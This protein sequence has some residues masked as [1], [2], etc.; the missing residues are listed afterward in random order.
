MEH[1]TDFTLA[2]L[3]RSNDQTIRRHAQ[4]IE[5]ALYR[6]EQQELDYTP[7]QCPTCKE[8]FKYVT[9]DGT[10]HNCYRFYN[11]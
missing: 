2:E 4:G 9:S 5:K 3:L 7:V 1:Y 10:C 8:M 6:K 11:Q